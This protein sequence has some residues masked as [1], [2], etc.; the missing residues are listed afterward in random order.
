MNPMV[1][2]ELRES[3]RMHDKEKTEACL[4]TLESMAK[5]A[6]ESENISRLRGYLERN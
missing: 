4:D 6:Q 5:S 2:K 1:T 3:V